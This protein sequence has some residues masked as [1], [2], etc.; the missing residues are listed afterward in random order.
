MT[1][2]ANSDSEMGSEKKRARESEDALPEKKKAKAN[3]FHLGW[4]HR[5]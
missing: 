5:G 4:M 3:R 1:G 2:S